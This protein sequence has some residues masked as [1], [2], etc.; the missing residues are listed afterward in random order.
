[1]GAWCAFARVADGADQSPLQVLLAADEIDQLF[2]EG[3]EEHA[4]DCE[5]APQRILA[6]RAEAD[7]VGASAVAV[8]DVLAKRGDFDLTGA[9]RSQHRDYAEGGADGERF[10]FAKD[11]PD[12]VGAGRSGDIIILWLAAHQFIAHAAARPIT[13]VLVRAELLD[14]FDGEPALFFGVEQEGSGFSRGQGTR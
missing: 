10:A 11:L 13:F 12:L 2:V 3:I 1:V 7:F 4:V 14:D 8:A 9:A 5:V 6:R